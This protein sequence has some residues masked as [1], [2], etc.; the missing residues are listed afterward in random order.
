MGKYVIGIDY[1][2]L[3]GRAILVDTQTGEEVAES[4]YEYPH[5]VM[6]E[7]LPCGKKL[8]PQ[9]AL[10]HPADYV[11][12]L[13]NTIPDILQVRARPNTDSRPLHRSYPS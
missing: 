6:D 9:Y 5:A 2:T 7:V 11:E 8:P 12:V 3:S 1:G 13:K 4:I 10:Q